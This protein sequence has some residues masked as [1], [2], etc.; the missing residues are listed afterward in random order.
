[1]KPYTYTGLYDAI[2]YGHIGIEEKKITP[3]VLH[4][5]FFDNIGRNYD[6]YS[7]SVL[8]TPKIFQLI[9]KHAPE[10]LDPK[11]V[12]KEALKDRCPFN[13]LVEYCPELIPTEVLTP[14][15]IKV[16]DKYG[17]VMAHFHKPM[18]I[19]QVIWG[20]Y[21]QHVNGIKNSM[22]ITPL[23]NLTEI[24]DL[25]SILKHA[26]KHSI[27]LQNLLQ[28]N[29]QG[30][31]S[32]SIDINKTHPIQGLDTLT[33]IEWRRR[34][35]SSE[36]LNK[37]KDFLNYS[38]TGVTPS[39]NSTMENLEKAITLQKSLKSNTNLLNIALQK[40]TKTPIK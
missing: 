3:T 10:L 17:K 1:M 14:E 39:K 32:V 20:F 15:I 5:F 23:Q 37:F 8:L 2:K 36:D 13:H 22:G 19:D 38:I 9:K 40:I 31:S 29:G 7:Q 12:Q 34:L 21:N 28:T 30:A 24:L 26:P 35:E 6:C 33:P 16:Q 27:S 25:S 11:L 18:A 4:E